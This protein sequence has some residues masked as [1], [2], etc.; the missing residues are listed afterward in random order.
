MSATLPPSPQ[1]PSTPQIAPS[2]W[3][4]VLVEM[5]ASGVPN[6]PDVIR[7]QKIRNVEGI[8]GRPLIIYATAW[9]TT[10]NLPP[11]VLQM[12]L[13]DVTGFRDVTESIQGTQIDV[14]LSTPGGL[15]EAA[16]SIVDLLR[17]RFTSV[18]FIV[19]LAAK[20]AG[21]MLAMSG[22]EL[23]MDDISELG[24]IDPQMPVGIGGM[25]RFA[26]ADEILSQFDE[27][28][29]DL[30][31]DPSRLPLWYPILSQMGPSLLAEC[32][33]AKKLSRD[34]VQRWLAQYMFAG[35]SQATAKADALADYL[36]NHMNFLSHGRRVKITDL[37]PYQPR[38]FDTRT[39]QALRQAIWDL[40]CA[41][42]ITF[43]NSPAAK[44][45]E[46]GQG[47]AVVVRHADQ[48]V[49]IG[50]PVPQ[51]PSPPTAPPVAP[52]APS[53]PSPSS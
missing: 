51:A 43:R 49:Q 18:R 44:I 2:T 25:V 37:Q 21:T 13:S 42:D 35:D 20:S 1:P 41:I 4:R 10:K 12:D 19:P 48:V 36:G 27:A 28:A 24:P 29:D 47:H 45:C 46:N 15:A 26:P 30:K 11:H 33:T 9:T 32:R 34:L 52:G 3:S 5:Q 14:L 31:Q 7:R 38:I 16:E 40:W 23:V 50:I 17:A 39:N 53:A 8:T 6:A 22:D